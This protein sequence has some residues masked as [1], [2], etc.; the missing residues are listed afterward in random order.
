MEHL[1]QVHAKLTSAPW[2][3]VCMVRWTMIR[4]RPRSATTET[5]TRTHSFTTSYS[6]TA[7]RWKRSHLQPMRGDSVHLSNLHI[8]ISSFFVLCV[9]RLVTIPTD[10]WC[11]AKS[12]DCHSHGPVTRCCALIGGDTWMDDMNPCIRHQTAPRCRYIW[13]KGSSEPLFWVSPTVWMVYVKL[14]IV[15]FTCGCIS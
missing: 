9:H 10:S 1:Q 14:S 11:G 13:S 3:I 2:V 5:S 15:F 8:P 7:R 6:S 4:N 12:R